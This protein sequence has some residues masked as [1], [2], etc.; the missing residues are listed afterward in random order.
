MVGLPAETP[1]SADVAKSAARRADA[2]KAV[3]DK[4]AKDLGPH[5]DK[6]KTLIRSIN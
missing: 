3:L 5:A 6:I 4:P 2:I 1:N